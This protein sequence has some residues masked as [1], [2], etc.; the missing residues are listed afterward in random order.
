MDKRYIFRRSVSDNQAHHQENLLGYLRG[1]D[2]I[3]KKYHMPKGE[4]F[5]PEARACASEYEN[6]Y[7]FGYISKQEY[8]YI[9][10]NLKLVYGSTDVVNDDIS[11]Y[12]L[13]EEKIIHRYLAIPQLD[14][15]FDEDY[16]NFEW[17]MHVGQN[18][19][20]HRNNYY[21]DHFI[22]QIRDMYMMLVMLDEFGFYDASANI[23]KKKGFSKISDYV[24]KR[25]SEFRNKNSSQIEVLKKIHDI[26]EED[27]TPDPIVDQEM[28]FS[29]FFYR[30][31]I[32]ASV[33]LSALFHDMGYPICHFLEV[34]Q[35]LSDYNPTLYMITHNST[36]S[37]DQ[38]ASL[39]N[40]SLL[41][42]LVPPYQI[43]KS[44]QMS[45]AGKYNHGAYSAISFLLQF[46]NN[47]IIFS[48]S[49]EK[50]CAIE[51]AALAIYN[52]TVKFNVVKYDENNAYYAPIFQQ[53][54]ISFLL[55]FCDDLQEWDR[56]YFEISESSDL[57]FCQKCGAPL[58]KTVKGGT[59]QYRCFCPDQDGLIRPDIFIKRKLYLV[60]VADTVS[61][62]HN[63]GS[64]VLDIYID[65]DPYKL[66]L[67]SNI[68]KT[69][70]KYRF[71]ELRGLKKLISYQNFNIAS[72]KVLPFKYINIGAFMTANP[73]LIKLKILERFLRCCDLNTHDKRSAP[74]DNLALI[75]EIDKWRSAAGCLLGNIFNDNQKLGTLLVHYTNKTI[76]FYL[77]LLKCCLQG[78]SDITVG[79]RAYIDDYQSKD[80]LYYD[81]LSILTEDCI[82]QYRNAQTAENRQCYYA[83]I[84]E[85]YYE[86]YAPNEYEDKLYHSIGV[87]T[88]MDNRFNCYDFLKEDVDKSSNAHPYISYYADVRVFQKMN[89]FM[90]SL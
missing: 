28:Y 85:A 62:N 20:E 31:V 64:D 77:D 36:N 42:T 38:L 8:G 33:M 4:A 84:N 87:Y 88:S 32:Y 82:R 69:Y 70:A 29:E 41:F 58:L 53:N 10:E 35:R 47:G 74:L 49:P 11:T 5:S 3:E 40:P 54:P 2:P 23:L 25:F 79:Y 86:A 19:R 63:D 80:P 73:I 18:F 51:L 67:L 39:L 17:D 90:I 46:Y 6:I 66:L 34:R 59:S 44:L 89:E 1:F 7:Q 83:P 43:K 56:R 52:H 26:M 14:K 16:F 15:M 60:T 75:R 68:N 61:V 9:Q 24:T 57:L 81:A 13:T 12:Y 37:F 78:L 30:Y 71:Q 45:K 50:Q 22:H 27:A 55:R 21:R 76:T 72:D 48:L 65:Y